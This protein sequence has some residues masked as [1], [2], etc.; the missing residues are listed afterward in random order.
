MRAC[1]QHLDSLL[2]QDAHYNT[3]HRTQQEQQ[4]ATAMH[5]FQYVRKSTYLFP[6]NSFTAH[7]WRPSVL[8]TNTPGSVEAG[9]DVLGCL[10]FPDSGSQFSCSRLRLLDSS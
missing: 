4:R 7:R 5:T 6:L 10:I 3:V 1:S 2:M 8:S 9:M